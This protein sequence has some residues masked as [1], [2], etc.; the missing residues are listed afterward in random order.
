[1]ER[2]D[3]PRSPAWRGRS[4]SDSMSMMMD[5][6]ESQARRVATNRLRNV[7][8]LLY[9]ALGVWIAFRALQSLNGAEGMAILF[10]AIWM[11]AIVA[12]VVLAYLFSL[13]ILGVL[14]RT[15]LPMAIVALLAIIAGP[16]L[17]GLIVFFE[18]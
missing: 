11:I 1:M 15:R 6:S 8:A 4:V 9:F 18:M 13:F 2:S 3:F 16:G 12:G 10:I 14:Y 17:L 7:L 5:Q